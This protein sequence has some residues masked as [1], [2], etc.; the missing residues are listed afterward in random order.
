MKIKA[1]NIFVTFIRFTSKIDSAT[2]IK[3]MPPTAVSSLTMVIDIFALKSMRFFLLVD[4][5][6]TGKAME[7]IC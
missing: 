2:P 4:K 3:S 6:Q 5:K 1:G 7:G